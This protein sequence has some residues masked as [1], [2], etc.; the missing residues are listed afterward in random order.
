[1]SK[2]LIFDAGPIINLSMN[3]LIYILEDLKKNFKGKFVITPQVKNEIYD[4]PIKVKRFQLEA[5]RVKALLDKGILEIS[6]SL[7]IDQNQLKKDT[8]TLLNEANQLIECKSKKCAQIVSEGEISCLALSKQLTEKGIENLIAIDERTT[9]I[10]SEKP[11]NLV[12]L[13]SKKLHQTVVL[14]NR[15]FE[16]FKNFKFIRSTELVYVAFKKGLTKVK[17]KQAQEALLYATKFKGSS[18]SFEEVETLKKL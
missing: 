7:D 12:K 13:M 9:R 8:Q 15:N 16:A 3:G 2:V 1:M 17:G 4:R 10:L 6:D 14:R 11:E 18:I 5:L